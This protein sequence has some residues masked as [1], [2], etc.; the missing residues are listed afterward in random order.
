M[1]QNTRDNP[2]EVI[3][4]DY[5]GVSLPEKDNYLQQCLEA[6]E[7][8]IKFIRQAETRSQIKMILLQLDSWLR[9]IKAATRGNESISNFRPGNTRGGNESNG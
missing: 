9:A 8:A 6:H 2:D 1:Y 7:E 3:I 5:P 4:L